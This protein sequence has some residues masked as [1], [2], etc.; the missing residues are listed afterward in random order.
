MVLFFSRIGKIN[1]VDLFI[2]KAGP[3][4]LTLKINETFDDY[5]KLV[6]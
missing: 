4:A 3:M 6:E 2:L 5:D 1:K